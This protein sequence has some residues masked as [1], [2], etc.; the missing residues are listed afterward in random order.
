MMNIQQKKMIIIVDDIE[1]W[2]MMKNS[3]NET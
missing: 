2:L 1:G 3:R